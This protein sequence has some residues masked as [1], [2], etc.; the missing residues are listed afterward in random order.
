[1]MLLRTDLS[2]VFFI[3][4]QLIRV[5]DLA[6]KDSSAMGLDF[7]DAF[8]LIAKSDAQT[9]ELTFARGGVGAVINPRYVCV[10]LGGGIGVQ[11]C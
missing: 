3:R 9:M 6:G 8:A 11:R 5:N 10:C 4:D 1:M 2:R 7:E